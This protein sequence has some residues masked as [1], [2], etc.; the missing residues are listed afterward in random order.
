MNDKIIYPDEKQKNKK[1]IIIGF[2]ITFV[3][4]LVIIGLIVAGSNKAIIKRSFSSI[5][6][7]LRYYTEIPNNNILMSDKFNLKGII[8]PTMQIDSNDTLNTN[9]NIEKLNQTKIKYE[10]NKN[11]EDVSSYYELNTDG[12]TIGNIKTISKDKI[13]Y[14]NLGESW[15]KI[16]DLDTINKDDLVYIKDLISDSLNNSIKK[17]YYSSSND[18]ITI[19]KE[20]KKV[21]KVSITLKNDEIYNV[22]NNI[23]K[24]LKK[25]KKAIKILKDNNID[26]KDIKLEKK[27][28]D[29]CKITYS[30]YKTS[31]YGKYIAYNLTLSDN[32]DTTS[33]SYK[34]DKNDEFKISYN[35]YNIILNATKKTNSVNMKLNVNNQEI[36]TLKYKSNKLENNISLNIYFDSYYIDIESTT[37]LQKQNKKYDLK[38]N[39][40]ISIK[41]NDKIVFDLNMENK[42][43]L[44][45]KASNIE[46]PKKYKDTFDDYNFYNFINNIV[47][48]YAIY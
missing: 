46:K 7:K 13:N 40:E 39:S 16:S 22:F 43:T 4:V 23:L 41:Y 3:I 42:S 12:Q 17:E 25:D 32:V 38:G 5:E 36:A 11:K 18:S 6:K 20:K 21:K 2:I 45:K 19:D 31:T 15:V 28:F 29:K 47:N 27:V 33:I 10:I 34:T 44:T 26:I 14:L 1:G 48:E 8:T 35:D 30:V 9:F 24:D 37:K